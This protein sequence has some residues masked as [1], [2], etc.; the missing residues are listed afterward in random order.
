[1]IT[2]GYCQFIVSVGEYITCECYY[3]FKKLFAS[4]CCAQ[5]CYNSMGS[6]LWLSQYPSAGKRQS[7]KAAYLGLIKHG[8]SLHWPHYEVRRLPQRTLARNYMDEKTRL[9]ARVRALQPRTGN[10][11]PAALVKS[12][13][14]KKTHSSMRK[15]DGGHVPS[16]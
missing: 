15:P 11:A 7:H 4:A 14:R 5:Q 2:R 3:L 6:I 9:Q 1:M 13:R 12:G 16:L 8:Q 10:A